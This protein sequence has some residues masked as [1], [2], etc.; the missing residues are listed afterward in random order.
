MLT[1]LEELLEQNRNYVLAPQEKEKQRRS[2]A[3]G[4]TVIEN[5]RVTREKVD[6]ETEALS[7]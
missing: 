5:P 3:Y 7:G 6:Q 1:R 2:F 4:N